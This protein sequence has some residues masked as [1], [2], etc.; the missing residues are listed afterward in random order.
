MPRCP[1]AARPSRR[2]RRSGGDRRQ[3]ALRRCTLVVLALEAHVRPVGVVRLDHAR[4]DA[5]AVD[6]DV[7]WATGDA[8]HA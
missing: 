6:G 4:V 5:Q 3:A 1:F 2:A 7:T 8:C